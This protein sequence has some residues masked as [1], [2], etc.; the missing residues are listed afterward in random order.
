MFIVTLNNPSDPN[1]WRKD[2]LAYILSH[3]TQPSPE[4]INVHIYV[5]IKMGLF[6]LCAVFLTIDFKI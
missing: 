2:N 4:N 5:Y 6:I 1:P 3:T